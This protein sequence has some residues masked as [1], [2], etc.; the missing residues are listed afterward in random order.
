[1][2]NKTTG[3]P[4]DENDRKVKSI[5]A[6]EPDRTQ[7]AAPDPFDPATLRLSQDF[8]S[9]V[10]V[11][12][13]LLT[14]PVRK[15]AKEWF[16]RVHPDEAYRFQ[17]A[18]I[19]LKE[20]RET[21]L[22]APPLRDQLAAEG[23]FGLRAMFTS[24]NRQGVV[25]LWPVRLPGADGRLDEWSRSAMEGAEMAKGG[26]VRVTSNMS[27]GAY[28]VY[29]A[30]ADIPDPTWPDMPFADLLRIAFRGRLIETLD[31]PVLKKLRGEA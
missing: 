24:I 25:F 31:H 19:E 1:M 5:A 22:V 6:P 28:E 8:A 7:D 26:W 2:S 4:A 13:A 29:E 17:T 3:V 15:P 9:Q 27:L 11:K 30:I 21:Y 10:G 23:T 16:V 18:V 20:D 14:V 12:K